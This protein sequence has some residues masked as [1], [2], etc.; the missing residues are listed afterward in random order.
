MILLPGTGV[1]AGEGVAERIRRDIAHHSFEIEGQE[2]KLTVSIGIAAF[3]RHGKTKEEI[4]KIA[5]QAMYHGKNM[6]R[7]VVYLAS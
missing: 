1:E 4:I 2:V 7:N 3:P 6:S 5:D